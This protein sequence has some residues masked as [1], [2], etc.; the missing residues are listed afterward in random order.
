MASRYELNHQHRGLDVDGSPIL[1]NP[2]F[3]DVK[4]GN[5]TEFE[6]NGTMIAKGAATCFKDVNRSIQTGRVSSSNAPTWTTFVGNLSLYRFAVNDYIQIAPFE[7]D[8]DWKQ[9]STLE[10]HLHWATNGTDISDRF[11]KWEIEYTFANSQNSGGTP[12]VFSTPTIIT[13]ETKIPANTPDRTHIYSSIGTLLPSTSIIGC[14][15]ITRLRRIA[16]TG[17]APTSNPFAIEQGIHYE[18]DTIGSKSR[19]H[20]YEED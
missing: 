4:G 7:L 8:H 16:S 14:Q 15:I 13:V 6:T 11:V 12:T 1:E 20:K 5:Y 3:G 9:P 17:T 2:K 18:V 19:M 10:F